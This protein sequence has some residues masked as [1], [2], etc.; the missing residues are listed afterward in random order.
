M[1]SRRVVILIG[2]LLLLGIAWWASR[3]EPG[4]LRQV[5]LLLGTT[6]EILAEHP[7]SSQLEAAV[8]AAFDE[9]DRVEQLMD[10]AAPGSDLARLSEAE[11]TFEVSADTARVIALGQ[12]MAERSGG[13]FDMSLGRLK[14]LW[15]LESERPQ[16]PDAAALREAL[17]GV[18]PRSLVIE[19]RLARKAVPQLRHDLGG[20]AKGYAVDRAVAILRQ[21]GVGSAAVNAGGDMYLLGE[22]SGRPWRIG[23]QHPRNP[24]SVLVAVDV[25]DRAVVT[26]GDYERFFEQDGQRYHHLFDPA[27]GV[28]ARTCQSVAVVADTVAEADALA[29]ALFV[30]GPAQGL[31][32]LTRYPGA[33][34]LFVMADGSLLRSSGWQEAATVQTATRE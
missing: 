30:L 9:I 13:A 17:V 7:D 18:G 1:A 20:V 34:A 8:A 28:P 24:E 23:I 32:L 33:D 14:A 4:Q 26:S 31:K 11:A 12:E 16:V 19:G 22:R 5:R 10:P 2:A 25:R 3:P 21:R 15:G 29:T 6:V 27:T